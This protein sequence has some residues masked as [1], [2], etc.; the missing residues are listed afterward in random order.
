VPDAASPNAA[1]KEFSPAEQAA[2]FAQL[3]T[4]FAAA[5]ALL[6]DPA[7]RVLLV[8]P[9]YRDHW[10]LPGGIL[11]HGEPP[12]V[13]CRRE[14]AEELGLDIEPGPLLVVGWSGPD[15]IR[16]RP[17]VHF[18]FDGG[19]LADDTQIRLQ[20]SEL[21]DYR[22]V[23]AD[24]L[25]RYLP[26]VISTRVSAGLRSRDTGATVY[27]PWPGRLPSRLPAGRRARYR[28]GAARTSRWS[29][30]VAVA[31][32]TA[33]TALPNASA[34][35]PAGARKPLI[36]RTYCRAAARMSSSVTCSANG[37]RRVLML[38]HMLL[39][40]LDRAPAPLLRYSVTRGRAGPRGPR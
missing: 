7:G 18:V 3:P 9:N 17:I 26:P 28:R 31:A 33:S 14:V 30:R 35:C 8:K 12:H 32:A 36:F 37:G 10:S 22:F 20:E 5:A 19:V 13:G 34:L 38:R 16:P 24:D 39:T 11:D 15:G 2:W 6:T 1:S 25:H 23:D 4:M 21:D 27:L 40:V 29:S